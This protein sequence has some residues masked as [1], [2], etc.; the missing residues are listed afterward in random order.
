MK[1][2]R[3]AIQLGSGEKEKS[4]NT[5]EQRV[6][7]ETIIDRFNAAALARQEQGIDDDIDLYNRYYENEVNDVPEYE[8]DPCSRTNI[9]KPLIE[10]SVADFVMASHD[11]TAKA[12]EPTD[13]AYAEEFEDFMEYIYEENQPEIQLDLFE[14]NRRKYGTGIFKTM[15]DPDGLNGFGLPIFKSVHPENFFPDPKVTRYD[16]LEEKSD[17]IIEAGFESIRWIKQT[18]K[19]RAKYVT[20]DTSLSYNL[21]ITSNLES[22]G[23][24]SDIGEVALLIWYWY[25]DDEGKLNL[26]IVADSE[27]LY[28]S[29]KKYKVKSDLDLEHLYKDNKYPYFVV[30]L[31]IVDGRL[32]GSSD[33]KD[34]IPI[35]DA[36]NDFDDQITL[37]ARLT[38]NNQTVVG[39]RA[40]IDLRK[41]T[42]LPGLK[43]PAKDE[44]AFK[45]VQPQSIP[46]YIINHREKKF[47]EA[48]FLTGRV[49]VLEGRNAP[50]VRTSSGILALQESA[51]KKINHSIAMVQIGMSQ[52][53]QRLADYAIDYYDEFIP[54]RQKKKDSSSKNDFRWID[55]SKWKSI[56]IKVPDPNTRVS[57]GSYDLMNLLDESGAI[58]E[59]RLTLSIQLKFNLGLQ[60]NTAFMYQAIRELHSENMIT[61]DEARTLLKQILDFPLIDPGKP[62]GEFLDQTLSKIRMQQQLEMNKLQN[63][64]NASNPQQQQ[65]PSTISDRG[66][67]MDN[68]D[69]RLMGAG[70][71]DPGTLNSLTAMLGGRDR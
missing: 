7:V 30:P 45:Q 56:P 25:K 46:Y 53:M 66:G 11:L 32:W 14:R 48:E 28:C 61:T 49:D 15:I 26:A 37:N 17:F 44:N 20:A 35:Q 65:N 47:D 60:N 29:E 5:E 39:T 1:M 57:D 58:K 3:Y 52:V 41:W 21:V 63:E 43:I 24:A 2:S 13:S 38:G 71:I 22:M 70:S 4:I 42:A 68:T 27:L 34:I 50:G 18:F 55:A 16:E 19:N 54:V 64:L 12:F 31:Y 59:R 62:M 51:K 36:I 69:P 10:S 9:V 33:I 40:K 67:Q 23:L 8:G 6:F